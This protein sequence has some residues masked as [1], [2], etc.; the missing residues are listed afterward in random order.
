MVH[1]IAG[2]EHAR[3]AG[4]GRIA[5]DTGLHFDVAVLQLQLAS[6][7][8]VFGLWPMATNKPATSRDSTL[9]LFLVSRRRRPLTPIWS[10]VTS[11][12][13]RSVCST[14][15]PLRHFIHQAFNEDFFRT[16]SESRRW[17]RVYLRGDIRQIQSLFHCAVLP[18]PITAT[19]WLR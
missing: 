13:V 5:V 14:M 3:D 19:F 17:I 12:R 15:L 11:S 16:G 7:M 4:L 18:P 9:S 6:K 10:P 1:D 8:A 2:G